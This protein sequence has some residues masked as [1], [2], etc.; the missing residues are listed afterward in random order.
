[1]AEP[2]RYDLFIVGGGPGGYTAALLGAKKGLRVGLAEGSHLG[3]TCTNTGCIPAKSYIESINLY[4]QI[5]TAQRFGLEAQSSPPVLLTLHRRTARIVGRLVKGIEYLLKKAGV[6]VYPGHAELV[7]KN[8]VRV[9]HE[10]FRCTSLI[11]ATGSQPKRPAMFDLPGVWTSEDIF[12]VTETP[13]SLIIV[14]GGAIGM[15]MAHVFGNL[16]TEVTVVE[17][18]ERVL[19]TEDE[20]VSRELTKLY[21]KIRFLTSAR[22]QALDASSGFA[23]TIES[24]EGAG[25]V[26]GQHLLLCIGRQPRIPAGV[27]E[28][29]VSLDASGGI[30]VDG[31]MQTDVPGV[32]AVGD[33]TGRH[34]YA[35]VAAK[36]AEIAID[37]LTGGSKSMDYSFIP[38]VVFTNPEVASVGKRMSEMDPS[39]TRR[40]TFPVSALGRARTM[41]ASDGFAHVYCTPDG[42]IERI[43]IMAPHATELISWATLAVSLG[44]GLEEFLKPHC[45]H[46][47]LAELLKEAAEDALGL[48]VHKP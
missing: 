7:G 35:F 4:T 6:T 3:G 28:L 21:R 46:P 8:T 30:E 37:H 42:K 18:L 32:Y 23:L 45:P 10:E 14:G 44:L 43:T 5:Q 2:I 34:M 13:S 36:E 22:I 38:S 17:A 47:T 25:T 1:M 31:F 41:D 12:E 29:G 26:T 15:E 39:V 33:V 27:P 19:A 24:P 40:G 16:G 11:I 9:A 20:D 48:S